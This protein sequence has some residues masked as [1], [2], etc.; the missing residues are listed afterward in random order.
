[1]SETPDPSGPSLR[2][3]G[4]EALI[5]RVA[6]LAPV[7]GGPAAG[8]GDDCAVVDD[9]QPP[10]GDD[11]L[12]L[13][14]TDALVERIHY[15]AGEDPGWVGW[16]AVARVAS[17]FAAMGGAPGR[18]LV[19]L[20][21]PADRPAAWVDALYRGMARAMRWCGGQLAGGE[22]TAVPDGSAAVISVAATGRVARRHL[23]LRSTARP[24]DV[25]YITGRLGGSLE[26]GRHLDFHPRLPEAAWLVRHFKPTAMMDLSDGLAADLPKLAR[27]S[28]AG[29]A[30][31]REAVP[32]QVGV[33]IEAAMNDGEDFE[34]L[35]T[36]PADAD[37]EEIEAKWRM[38][39][40]E[41]ALTRIGMMTAEPPDV[42]PGDGWS[43]FR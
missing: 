29:F 40:P 8:P 42:G 35:F 2:E 36:Q 14:K 38:A 7:P 30:L 22:T 43:H 6:A 16:K 25:I 27:A 26:S 13:L 21:L 39:F 24:G 41:V 37:S 33:T 34:L 9:F 15:R 5:E 20:A 31:D 28:G 4:E 10:R 18:F 1:M 12:L 11:P 19:T 3:I 17:D 32:R 23:V